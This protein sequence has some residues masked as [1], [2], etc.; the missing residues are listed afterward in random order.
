MSSS[1]TFMSTPVMWKLADNPIILAT[2]SPAR[3]R[4]FKDARIAH[5][6]IAANLD[7]DALRAA[8]SHENMSPEDTASMLAEAKAMKI[9]AL[10]P[11]ALVMASDQLL[12]CDDVIYSKPANRS[13][14]KTSLQQLAGKTHELITA[15]IILLAGQRLWHVVKSPKITLRTLNDHDINLYLDAMGD[16]A[17]MTPGVYMIEQLGVHIISQMDGCSYTIQG[18]PMLECLDYLRR[19]GLEPVQS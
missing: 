13:A 4:M 17:F 8:A 16:T 18:F 6:A 14:A 5:T 19:F 9:S 7:E 3:L 11:T 10:H 12:V 2:E 15:G 1:S